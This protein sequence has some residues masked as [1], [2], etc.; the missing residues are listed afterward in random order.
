MGISKTFN[1][2]LVWVVEPS[3]AISNYIFN[4]F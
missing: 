1:V 3:N 2:D 4:I